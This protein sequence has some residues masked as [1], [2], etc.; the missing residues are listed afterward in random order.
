MATVY[1]PYDDA[2]EA[3]LVEGMTV[4][5]VRTLADLAAHLNGDRPPRHREAEATLRPPRLEFEAGT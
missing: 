1:V 4:I 3:A 2:A 5:P